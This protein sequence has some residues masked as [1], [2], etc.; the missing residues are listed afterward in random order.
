MARPQGYDAI[1]EIAGN[2]LDRVEEDQPLLPDNGGNGRR[3]KG[4]NWGSWFYYSCLTI[5]VLAGVV[6][7]LFNMLGG[8]GGGI[9]IASDTVRRRAL[10]GGSAA[11]PLRCSA[12][13]Q[14]D[15]S[16]PPGPQPPAETTTTLLPQR[17]GVPFVTAAHPLRPTALWGAVKPPY[18]TGAWF[19]NLVIGAGDQPVV[20]L[21]YAVRAGAHGIDVSF[22]AVRRQ[23]SRRRITD[24]FDA[25]LTV[26]AAEGYLGHALTRYDNLSASVSHELRGGAAFATH[27]VRG[28]PYMTFA[29]ERE[30]AAAL[31]A[32][33]AL[34]AA[35]LAA[36]AAP[37]MSFGP[38]IRAAQYKDATPTLATA[39]SILA[40]DGKP[41]KEGATVRGKTFKLGLSN[42]ETWMVYTSE[43]VSFKVE[44]RSFT[45]LMPMSGMLRAA[46]LPRAGDGEAE[47]ELNEH[48]YAYAKGGELN[49]HA[50]AYAKGGELNERAYAYTKG[51]ETQ[52]GF[53]RDTLI[54]F[55]VDG[56]TLVTKFVWEKYGFGDLL[57]LA[58]P[59]HIDMMDMETTE[60]A[61]PK[62][63]QTLKPTEAATPKAYH[64]TLEA[65]AAV[66]IEVE[67]LPRHIKPDMELTAVAVPGA[68]QT[69]KGRMTGVVGTSWE[70]REA[71]TAVGWGT[72]GLAGGWGADRADE[73]RAELVKD[74]STEHPT[75]ADIYGFS[76][77]SARM[78]R[79]ALIA[80]ELGEMGYRD[81]QAVSVIEDAM[82]AWLRND[83][84]DLL[85]YDKTW[86]GVV[87]YDGLNDAAADFGN[88]WIAAHTYDG[89][90]DAAADFGNGWYNAHHFH[91][92][93]FLYNDHHFHYGYFLYAAAVVA[94]NRPGFYPA[95][96]RQL[97][98]MVSDIACHRALA[99]RFPTAR[100][101]DFFDG[102]RPQC[103]RSALRLPHAASAAHRFE[104]LCLYRAVRAVQL[105]V[106]PTVTGPTTVDDLWASGLF[107]QG[108]G[109]SQESSSE[110]VNA[111]YAVYLLGM[112][113]GN[114]ELRDWG[115]I[116]LA[117]EMAAVKPAAR[118]YK[119][120]A[121]TGNK[122][123]RDWGRILL[124]GE[125]RSTDKYWHMRNDSDV[126]DSIF[127][128][129]R[130]V[131][132][133][134][135]LDAVDVTWFGDNV[136]Y[137]HGINM[138]PFT[139]ISAELLPYGYMREEW[140]M[141]ATAL[142]REDP[143]LVAQWEGY[144]HLAH[145]ILDPE[146]AWSGISDLTVFDA[147][148][149][150]TNSLHWVA[151]RPAP[152][153]GYNETLYAEMN[154]AAAVTVP[155][156]CLE[157]SACE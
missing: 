47:F 22:S 109:K 119:H 44:A 59:H 112:A 136:E 137:V 139:P 81:Q 30:P 87:T 117:G 65:S 82:A 85:V 105:S 28:S 10:S 156:S 26:G 114:R 2:S 19:T 78:A 144:I 11:A 48:A 83:N 29:A 62:A 134:G 43:S 147:A 42:W 14:S 20:P 69:R 102:H 130:M 37:A 153:P 135:G 40:L 9:P 71:L 74:I 145:A 31:L 132:V 154:A 27:L 38:L 58:L 143:P 115:R 97:D 8:G 80:E 15:P 89:L 90:N 88:G 111:Y 157:N 98:F 104:V 52:L 35:A 91:Y 33:A 128:S 103:P 45:A 127:A 120:F 3:S 46:L 122:E 36:A 24:V 107:S 94:K 148:N 6:S 18:P 41:L 49:E 106:Q 150:K 34:A 93:Y 50:Y 151:S 96:R 64:Q 110:A 68:Y 140:P 63:Y 23:A 118:L 155:V 1:R 86:G 16:H 100:H 12:A 146:A 57:M 55:D 138:M 124:A 99:D 113:T 131:G 17:A 53:D 60:V 32:A 108:N 92:G 39:T 5:V 123:L 72:G 95:Y 13:V 7:L 141:L 56:D 70:M 121:S 21:P 101:K 142:T 67:A 116:L 4:C 129:N 51:G 133:V 126:Y 76:K 73:I 75:A 25:D 84:S 54:Q 79:L 125:L 149:S 77:Q 61:M 152:P 66:L